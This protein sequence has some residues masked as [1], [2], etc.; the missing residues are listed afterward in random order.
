[1]AMPVA[2]TAYLRRLVAVPFVL[3]TISLAAAEGSDE[4]AGL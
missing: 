2:A 4:G 1:M 3:A